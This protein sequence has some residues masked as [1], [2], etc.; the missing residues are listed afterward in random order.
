MGHTDTNPEDGAHYSL[1]LQNFVLSYYT[2]YHSVGNY[3]TVVSACLNTAEIRKDA[4][5]I[6]YSRDKMVQL[7]GALRMTEFVDLDISVSSQ[8]VSC[9]RVGV[10]GRYDK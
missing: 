6:Y 7:W 8:G 9:V 3:T 4:V 10:F 2:E 1:G 5:K